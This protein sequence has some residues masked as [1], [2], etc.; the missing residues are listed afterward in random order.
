MISALLAV[1]GYGGMGYKGTLP[2][3]VSEDLQKFKELTTGQIVVMGRKTW[4]DKKFPK[5]LVNRTCYVVT[6]NPDTLGPHAEALDG[7]NIEKSI[8][9]LE[10]KHPGKTIYVIGGPRIIMQAKNILDQIHLTQIAGEYKTDVKIKITDLI[11]NEYIPR[12]SSSGPHH[13]ATFIRYEKL[14]IIQ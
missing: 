8:T 14:K 11:T 5:P 4:D 12:S 3:Y 2:W 1:D 9:E 10:F 6:S 13:K 7:S